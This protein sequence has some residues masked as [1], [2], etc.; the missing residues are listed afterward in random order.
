MRRTFEEFFKIGLKRDPGYLVDEPAG[1]IVNLGAGRKDRELLP[2]STMHL[3]LPNWRAPSLQGLRDGDFAVVHAHH[4][5]EH[6]E[7]DEAIQMLREIER[8]LMPRGVCYI[9]VPYAGAQLSFADITHRSFWNEE[10]FKH[11]MDNG[12]YNPTPGEEPWKLTITYQ[13]IAAVAYRNLALFVQL[14]KEP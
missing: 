3:G 14:V 9:T 8:V 10:T 5:L 13:V 2:P 7:S 4:F 12:Y 11:L 6:L 1:P